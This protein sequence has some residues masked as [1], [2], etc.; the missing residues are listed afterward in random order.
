M[1][2]SRLRDNRVLRLAVFV[3][4][5][6]IFIG[7][8]AYGLNML[9]GVIDIMGTVSIR[10]NVEMIPNK[11]NIDLGVI[12]SP[13][14]SKSFSNIAKLYVRNSSKIIAK[15]D[16]PSIQT[17]SNLSIILSGILKLEGANRSYEIHMPCLYSNTQCI[18]ILV[19]IPGYDAPLDI[20]RGEYNVSLEISW[21]IEGSGDASIRMS[22]QI[23]EVS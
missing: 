23:L 12:S 6:V 10:S 14:G 18:R 15:I 9:I 4:A 5:V 8:M 11:V 22:L 3:M 1:F 16:S 13:S 7:V 19:L 20:D 17:S 21:M 2:W